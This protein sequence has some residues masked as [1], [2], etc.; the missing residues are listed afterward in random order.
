MSNNFWNL[1]NPNIIHIWRHKSVQCGLCSKTLRSDHLSRHQKVHRKQEKYKM[2]RCVVC[3][4]SNESWKPNTSPQNTFMF[5]EANPTGYE[6]R[7]KVI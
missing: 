2:K 7:S 3:K 4:K 5:F 6:N 1:Q